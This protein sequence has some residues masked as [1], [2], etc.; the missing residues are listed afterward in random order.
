[1]LPR[2]RS[3]KLP[4]EKKKRDES[5]LAEPSTS[6]STSDPSTT[7][8]VFRQATLFTHVQ[9]LNARHR[10]QLT[11]KFQLAHEISTT[12]LYTLP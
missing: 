2:A 11:E 7:T 4:S 10:V 8:G 1:M 5:Q 6:S 3:T 9:K 12:T